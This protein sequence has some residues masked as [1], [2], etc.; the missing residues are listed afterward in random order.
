MKNIEYPYLPEGKELKYTDENNPFMLAAKD[1][2]SQRAGDS[3]FPVG[4]VLVKDEKVLIEAGNGFDKGA[5]EVHVCPRVV[6]ECP[7]GTGYELCSLHDSPGHAE[8]MAVKKAQEQGVDISGADAY[9]YGHWWACEPCWDALLSSGIKDLYVLHDAHEQFSREAVYAR[10]LQPTVKSAY[11]AGAITNLSPEEY[12]Q[13]RALYDAI[14]EVCDAMGVTS[15]IPHRD[16]G[17]NQ[18]PNKSSEEIYRW[19]TQQARENHVTIA[20]VSFPSLGTGG[21]LEVAHA[22]GNK[23]ILL[24]KKGARVSSYVKGNPSVVF[25][26]EYTSIEEATRKVQNVL[27]QI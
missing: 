3:L 8:Q 22:Q 15:C 6:E 10:T 26:V 1:A 27:K 17:E 23:I 18:N 25:H 19:S 14:G 24:S 16:K 13:Q 12:E 20:E 9:M 4:I 21:E 5:S 11:V 7:S 2:Q